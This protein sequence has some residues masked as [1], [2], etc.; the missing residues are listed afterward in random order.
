MSQLGH[1]ASNVSMLKLSSQ[2]EQRITMG[3]GMGI[4]P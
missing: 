2:F 3:A 4:E 1:F